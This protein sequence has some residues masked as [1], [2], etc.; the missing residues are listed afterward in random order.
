MIFGIENWHSV[1]AGVVRVV[2]LGVIAIVVLLVDA[3]RVDFVTVVIDISSESSVVT[4]VGRYS[5]LRSGSS[6]GI[7]GGM[8]VVSGLLVMAV[9]IIRVLWLSIRDMT[10][11]I[12][13]AVMF[14]ILNRVV[15]VISWSHCIVNDRR[16]CGD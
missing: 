9:D 12:T 4:A 8:V 5:W 7:A 16:S 14:N 1:V 11:C 15:L 10:R 6:R 13:V 2:Q 3:C